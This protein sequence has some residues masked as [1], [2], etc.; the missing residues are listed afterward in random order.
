MKNRLVLL[1]IVLLMNVGLIGQINWIDKG[2][3]QGIKVHALAINT[4]GDIFAGRDTGSVLLS[5]NNGEDWVYRSIPSLNAKITTLRCSPNGDVFAGTSTSG[6]FKTSDNGI[7][8]THTSFPGRSII[9]FEIDT[10]GIMY[11]LKDTVSTYAT[12]A[13]YTSADQGVTWFSIILPPL[14]YPERY[15][16]LSC[17]GNGEICISNTDNSSYY[18]L[19]HGTTWNSSGL[20]FE[21]VVK[22]PS[23]GKYFLTDR[24]STVEVYS[25]TTW[26]GPYTNINSFPGNEPTSI[27]V[28][29]NGD[30]YVGQYDL[31]GSFGKL[32]FSNDHG[33]TWSFTDDNPICLVYDEFSDVLF[34]SNDNPSGSTCYNYRGVKRLSNAFDLSLQ[35]NENL[36]ISLGIS[37][38]LCAD[39]VLG[40][41]NSNR[42]YAYMLRKS[43][44][45]SNP[46][47]GL[48]ITENNG[49]SWKSIPAFKAY[50][51]D[52][53]A[54]D[55]NSG[56]TYVAYS[57]ASPTPGG[58]KRK[59]VD[60]TNWTSVSVSLDTAIK[61]LAFGPNGDVY[62]LMI[63]RKSVYRSTDGGYTWSRFPISCLTI[64]NQIQTFTVTSNNT[65][66]VSL[67]N[68]FTYRSVDGG[69][70]WQA[71]TSGRADYMY[72]NKHN[73]DIFLIDNTWTHL[74]QKSNDDGLT[75]DTLGGNLMFGSLIAD[76][77]F[78]ACGEIYVAA[79]SIHKSNDGGISWAT[80]AAGLGTFP[81]LSIGGT[82]GFLY[83]ANNTGKV[84]R[85]LQ[86]ISIVQNCSLVW[87]GD[88]DRDLVV[89]NYDLLP[90]GLHYGD[91]GTPRSTVSNNWHGYI[92]NNWGTA[93]INGN[94]IKNIDCNGDGTITGFDT[95]AI[96][97]NYSNTHFRSSD[98]IS[99]TASTDNKIYLK[100]SSES[101]APGQVV[102]VEIWAGSQAFPVTLYGLGFNISCD[103]S[104]I[105]SSDS[106]IDYSY[107]WLGS[108][109]T[110]LTLS[111]VLNNGIDGAIVRTN[112]VDTSGYGKIADLYIHINPNINVLTDLILDVENYKVIDANGNIIPF[113]SEKDTIQINPL[114]L[115]ITEIDKNSISIY[116]NPFTDR[117]HLSYNFENNADVKIEIVDELGLL[118]DKHEFINQSG[119]QSSIEILFPSDKYSGGIYFL[120][121]KI[122]NKI[123][124]KKIVKI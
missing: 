88:A 48:L 18:S 114:F 35:E 55:P 78:N 77:Y 16:N 104:L 10:A 46:A 26:G 117:L 64:L 99:E 5:S 20:Y 95:V 124:I 59:A 42:L 15:N 22:D 91:S 81:N 45:Y 11:V 79:N 58:L 31:Q 103:Q 82:N 17:L 6:I 37:G 19:N 52:L 75:W 14:N 97:Q 32:Y 65:L 122:D 83:V 70:T 43:Y 100:T 106:Y 27:L 56:A 113:V 51:V 30:L 92:S 36:T 90:I 25:M 54:E 13:L 96:L 69:L 3:I 8:W 40:S 34:Y 28:S 116:P 72:V 93:Q 105:V 111:K 121:I 110:N 73:G 23:T 112:S 47:A 1:I 7:S 115:N 53:V 84:Y 102:D 94:D 67:S 61:Q 62:A 87:P 98:A 66:M 76:M 49:T 108:P 57:W 24:L 41:L 38:H 118:R 89:N 85:S 109:V 71:M 9:T 12:N 107:S 2:G 29:S 21:K 39:K 86:D 60:S 74:F 50:F 63:N 68:S 123:Y 120:K 119:K 44:C 80:D 33:V 101:Y 4:T